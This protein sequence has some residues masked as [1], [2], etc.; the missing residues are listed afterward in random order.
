MAVDPDIAATAVILPAPAV[1]TLLTN[2][3]NRGVGV[4]VLTQA[5]ADDLLAQTAAAQQAGQAF[6]A[7]TMFGV[8]GR[9]N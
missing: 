7:V 3:T 4:G 9:K 8:L 1:T 2:A 5:E 6:M